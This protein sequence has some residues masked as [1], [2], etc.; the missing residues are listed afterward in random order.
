VACG[1]GKQVSKGAHT[2]SAPCWNAAPDKHS[3]NALECRAVVIERL[4]DDV[5]N[6]AVVVKTKKAKKAEQSRAEQ[7]QK[8]YRLT[9]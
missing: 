3:N 7:S 6:T 9:R 8:R 5:V 2:H 1:R 4:K